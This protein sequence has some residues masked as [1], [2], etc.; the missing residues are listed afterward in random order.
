MSVKS[1]RP[2]V[3]NKEGGWGVQGFWCV[4]TLCRSF[5]STQQS[6]MAGANQK[7]AEKKKR[8]RQR[9]C[10]EEEEEPIVI[11]SSWDSNAW[12]N[13]WAKQKGSSDGVNV[14]G[15]LQDKMGRHYGNEKRVGNWLVNW[16]YISWVSY[17]NSVKRKEKHCSY[18]LFTINTSGLFFLCLCCLLLLLHNAIYRRLHYR[19]WSMS[20]VW[21]CQAL[22]GFTTPYCLQLD[23]EYP[24]KILHL[25]WCLI[26]CWY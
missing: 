13:K 7:E 21:I 22:G 18:L 2:R 23:R 10:S 19:H 17:Y 3:P 1:I 6:T 24:G 8:R 11:G 25:V 14:V 4:Y 16:T 5:F 9:C 15:L 20:V 12:K 26:P